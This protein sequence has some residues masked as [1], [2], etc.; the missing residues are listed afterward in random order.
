MV[1]LTTLPGQN[2]RQIHNARPVRVTV[3]QPINVYSKFLQLLVPVDIA[4]ILPKKYVKSILH[5]QVGA[6]IIPAQTDVSVQQTG[7]VH[8]MGIRIPVNQ[9]VTVI[10]ANRVIVVKGHHMIARNIR[11]CVHLLSLLLV[12][13]CLH[14]IMVRLLLA[15]IQQVAG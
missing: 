11:Q 12:V 9:R 13:I 6:A 5:V 4:I 7:T 3:I 15:L 8:K 2:V 14:L 1:I 10:V